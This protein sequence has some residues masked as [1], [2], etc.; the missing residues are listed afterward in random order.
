MSEPI[1]VFL[2]NRDSVHRE[3]I[4]EAKGRQLTG[5]PDQI[6]LV[7]TNR[8]N[9]VLQ[10]HEWF[11]TREEAVEA[12]A[13]LLG[14]R[15]RQFSYDVLKLQNEKRVLRELEIKLQEEQAKAEGDLN[16]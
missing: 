11:T 12:L 13:F 3:G 6:T 10:K 8:P 15:W 4:V 14:R 5:H 1:T 9:K 2:L 7:G 16:G